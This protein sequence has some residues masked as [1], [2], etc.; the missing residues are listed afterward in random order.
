[1]TVHVLVPGEMTVKSG[2]DLV[3]RIETD[4]R[5]SIGEIVVTTHLE[6]L[7][8]PASFVHGENGDQPYPGRESLLPEPTKR[9]GQDGRERR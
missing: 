6:P 3:D 5:V 8:D 2:H 1:M 9:N 4:I 7:E